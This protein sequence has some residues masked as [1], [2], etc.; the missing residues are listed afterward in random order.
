[1]TRTDSGWIYC[2]LQSGS[3]SYFQTACMKK[4]GT[5]LETTTRQTPFILSLAPKCLKVCRWDRRGC[6]T[7][8]LV[9]QNGEQNP[10]G[11]WWADVFA[12]G[13]ALC[14]GGQQCVG[15]CFPGVPNRLRSPLGT[16]CGRSVFVCPLCQWRLQALHLVVY[17]AYL[18]DPV[19]LTTRRDAYAGFQ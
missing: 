4:R 17:P 19:E 9:L 3:S 2:R 7:L 8:K 11:S 12:S 5:E 18:T 6:S 1:M 15:L 14:S 16:G 10:H 13:T